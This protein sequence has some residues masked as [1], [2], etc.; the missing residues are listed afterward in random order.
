MMNEPRFWLCRI[1]A[2]LAV[3][4]TAGIGLGDPTS[5]HHQSLTADGAGGALALLVLVG[6]SV[7]TLIDTIGY[8]L[9]GTRKCL[10]L[11]LR[12]FRFLWLMG[13]ATGMAALVLVNVRWGDV[14]PVVLRYLLDGVMATWLAAMDIKTRR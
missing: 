13:M 14:E 11:T 4:V 2:C 6:F 3:M 7:T 9:I 5:Q 1:Y 10:F 8:D 12:R